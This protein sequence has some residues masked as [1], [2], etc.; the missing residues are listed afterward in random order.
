MFTEFCVSCL[1]QLILSVARLRSPTAFILLLSH[2]KLFKSVY[3][4]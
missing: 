4:S 2:R 3:C 1:I